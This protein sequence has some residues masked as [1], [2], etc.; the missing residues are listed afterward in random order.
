[1]KD[2]FKV[3]FFDESG[4]Y[5]ESYQGSSNEDL[6]KKI[7]ENPTYGWIKIFDKTVDIDRKV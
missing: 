5:V 1:M 7:S 2:Y 6:N 4:K 3:H